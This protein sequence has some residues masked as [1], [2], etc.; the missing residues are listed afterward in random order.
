M[1]TTLTL[2]DACRLP[3]TPEELATTP[4][5]QPRNLAEAMAA[6]MGVPLPPVEGGLRIEG[7]LHECCREEL[8]ALLATAAGAIAERAASDT[9]ILM[10]A[11]RGGGDA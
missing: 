1:R 3:M 4:S 7:H 8:E 11:F 10:R 5:R 2:C 9:E 6:S